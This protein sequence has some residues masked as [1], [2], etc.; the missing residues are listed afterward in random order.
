MSKETASKHFILFGIVLAVLSV[1]LG[2]FGAHGLKGQIEPSSLDSFRTGIRYQMFHALGLILF[3]SMN[4]V[5]QS[6]LGRLGAWAF[7]IGTVFFSG[8]IYLLTTSKVTGIGMT[9][10]L[11]PMTPIGGVFLIIG[12]FLF[13]FAVLKT[14]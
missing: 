7:V 13:M 10:V 6:G 3:A 1:I 4:S 12:W 2:A 9:S 14:K 5:I 11:G 8:S